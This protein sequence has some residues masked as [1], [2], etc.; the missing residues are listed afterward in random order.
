M[1]FPEFGIKEVLP[2]APGH[3]CVYRECERDENALRV[4]SVEIRGPETNRCSNKRELATTRLAVLAICQLGLRVSEL[5]HRVG[6]GGAYETAYTHQRQYNHTCAS[7]HPS[8]A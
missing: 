1:N 5:E 4:S 6:H 2:N 7:L 8:T 3:G